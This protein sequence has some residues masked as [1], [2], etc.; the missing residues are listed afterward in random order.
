LVK[1]RLGKKVKFDQVMM[2]GIIWSGGGYNGHYGDYGDGY[3]SLF[4][5][6]HLFND[7]NSIM[8]FLFLQER[9]HISQEHTQMFV[10]I[11][12][13]YYYG[14]LGCSNKLGSIKC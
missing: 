12:E 14:H 7:K 5:Q 11:A 6:T 4:L 9:M 3:S 1:N 2:I 10:A 13:R 8:K